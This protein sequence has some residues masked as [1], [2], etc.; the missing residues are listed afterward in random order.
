MHIQ[1]SKKAGF[2]T[3]DLI[4]DTSQNKPE[5][6]GFQVFLVTPDKDFCPIGF[7]KYFQKANNQEWE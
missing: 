7:G 1:L 4:G 5:K 2:E 6:K 3:D